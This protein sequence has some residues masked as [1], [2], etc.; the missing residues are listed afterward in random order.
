MNPKDFDCD[1]CTHKQ[2]DDTNPAGYDRW[3]IEGVIVSRVCLLPLIEEAS[4]TYL[5]LY[6][7]YKNGILIFGG[8]LLNQP[9]PYI[10]AMS[11]IDERLE[12]NASNRH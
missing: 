8:G 7:H 9:N 11:I 10:E 12:N 2:C 3:E 5:S 6:R 4:R 1:K